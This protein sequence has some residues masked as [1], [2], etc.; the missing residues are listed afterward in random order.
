[1][2]EPNVDRQRVLRSLL[3]LNR[4]LESVLGELVGIS[5]DADEEVVI[6][7]PEH[8][9][10]VLKRFQGGR[11]R[12]ED[13]ERWANAIEGRDD[14][15]VEV[16]S[17]VVLNEAIFDL[18]NPKLQGALTREVAEQWVERLQRHER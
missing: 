12:A 11:L 6:L 4:T 3:E 14:I 7:H 1:M 5:W 10:E 8:V 2:S 9:I 18:A 17:R 16:A 13:V 15:G